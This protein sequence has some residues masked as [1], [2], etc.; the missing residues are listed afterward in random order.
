MKIKE[1]TNY[2]ESLAP[3]SLQ[4]SYDNSGLLVGDQSK[5]IKS[6]LI[7]LDVTEEVVQEAVSK[8]A[9]LIISHHPLIFK[10]IK[11]ITGK[12]YVE[13]TLLAAIKN[14]IAI[15]ALHTNLDNVARGVN[16]RIAEKLNLQN[17]QIL[18]P[19]SGHL[20]KLVTF[21]P[22]SHFEKVQQA[23]LTS[24][25]GQIGNYDYCGF[26]TDG[27]G[28]FR[29]GEDTNPYVGKKGEIHTEEEIKLETIYPKH[30]EYQVIQ[31]LIKNH[32]YE[33]PAYDIFPLHNPHPQIGSGMIGS[34]PEKIPVET[35]LKNVKK[36]LRCECLK[37]TKTI[38]KEVQKIAFCGGS[39]QF[40]LADAIQQKADVFI[41]SDF[42]YHDFFEANEQI[43]IVDA[44]HYETEQFTKNLIY[45]ALTKKNSKF[46]CF[47][48]DINTNPIK[49]L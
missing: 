44:G 35:F 18:R 41:S 38:K 40:L 28:S 49:Y 34:L 31:S 42:K 22:R 30:A 47:L 11:R 4:E 6:A 10:G 13:R 8:G 48:S 7:T 24:G 19:L 23:I 46:A 16:G 21:I 37:Y 33:E 15:Y 17:R 5:E 12:N 45:D 36:Q 2:L 1:I 26:Y 3:L 39:G 25:A 32:P 29:A 27:K 43:I 20:R 14:D 9:E